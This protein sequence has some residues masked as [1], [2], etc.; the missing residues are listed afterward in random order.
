[1]DGAPKKPIAQSDFGKIN[2]LSQC[3]AEY[4]NRCGNI[5]QNCGFESGDL[6]GW[7]QGGNLSYTFVDGEFAHSGNYALN[8]GPISTLGYISQNLPTTSGQTYYL[9]FWLSNPPPP[10]QF[11]VI[12]D[13]NVVMATTDLDPFD[14]TQFEIDNLWATS[15]S[16]E[17]VFAFYNPPDF[18]HFDDV[19]VCVQ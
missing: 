18:F 8:A 11:V 6:L 5:V 4:N 13:G 9:T 17:L 19:V 14:Y 10:S 12:W 3:D 1:M 2:T 15:T 16:T 7:V